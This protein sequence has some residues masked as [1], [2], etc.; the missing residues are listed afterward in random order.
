MLVGPGEVQTAELD[1]CLNI[2]DKGKGRFIN[3]P[4]VTSAEMSGRKEEITSIFS[5][6][7]EN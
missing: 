5:N 1:T 3:K 6:N 2:G 4:E 7:E